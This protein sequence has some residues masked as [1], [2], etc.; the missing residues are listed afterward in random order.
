MKIVLGAHSQATH[1]HAID[2]LSRM[3]FAEPEVTAVSAA[4]P[5]YSVPVTM[6]SSMALSSDVFR[7]LHTAAVA[8]AEQAANEL[9]SR[10]IRTH[11]KVADG[12]AADAL[13]RVADEISAD[14][15]AVGSEQK[16]A[17]GA[18]FLGS[19]TRALAAGAKQSILVARPTI[20]SGPVRAVLAVD[21]SA[22]CDRCVDHL[23]NF[24]PK[25]LGHVTVLQV[26]EPVV[27]T[28]SAAVHVPIAT[29]Q[30]VYARMEE[31]A[32][33]HT[34]QVVDK[35]TAAGIEASPVVRTGPVLVTIR[36]V[37]Q[38][39]DSEMIIL[40]AQGHGFMHRVL[41]GSIAMHVVASESYSA[42]IMR[43]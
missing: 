34:Q 29:T 28:M 8:N 26:I 42:L 20:A 5:I 36:K 40:G 25:G 16:S 38:D 18:L 41:I 1:Q 43:A 17:I 31:F 4:E 11:A 13:M 7:A 32:T 33:N 37:V 30:E 24:Q 27:D 35:L 9:N 19:V 21:G 12:L 22:Y 10:G 3:Q 6:S 23:I 2:L 39:T 15:I 14:L